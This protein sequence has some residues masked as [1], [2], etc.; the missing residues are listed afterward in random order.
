MKIE[1]EPYLT[2]V[3]QKTHKPSQILLSPVLTGRTNMLANKEVLIL[4]KS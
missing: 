3:A 1:A 2:E 4:I